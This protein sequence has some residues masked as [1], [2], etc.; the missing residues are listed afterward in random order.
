VSEDLRLGRQS[1]FRRLVGGSPERSPARSVAVVSGKGG[2]G[3]SVV[4]A[5]LAYRTVAAG[6]RSLVFD[7]DFGVGNAHILQ[8]LVAELTVA[9]VLLG[10]CGLEQVAAVAP[11]GVRVIPGGSGVV[12]I[13]SPSWIQ[14]R[15]LSRG[16]AALEE[17]CDLL[18]LDGPAGV[19]DTAVLLA[20]CA[21]LVVVVTTPDV[22][23]MT[24]AYAWIKV[25]TQRDPETR[26]GLVVN[27]VRNPSEADAA[28]ARIRTVAQRFLGRDIPCLGYLPEDAAVVES[29]SRRR[30]FPLTHPEAPVSAAFESIARAVEE[31]TKTPSGYARRLERSLASSEGRDAASSLLHPA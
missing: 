31:A 6:G 22:T 29:V 3:K 10:R 18:V 4:S 26:L 8:G 5:A 16:L 7:V 21:D 27:R 2:T 11:T 24:D 14:L 25:S 15:L 30:P 17:R 9:H 12:G 28:A 13:S 1:L 20:G 19:A 23:A